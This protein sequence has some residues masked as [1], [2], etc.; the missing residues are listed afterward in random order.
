[1]HLL[2]ARQSGRHLSG[3]KMVQNQH[4]LANPF[5]RSCGTTSSLQDLLQC[6][7][8]RAQLLDAI[9]PQPLLRSQLFGSHALTCIWMPH[10]RQEL[11][12]TSIPFSLLPVAEVCS[13]LQCGQLPWLIDCCL[14]H[15]VSICCIAL[16]S[17]SC[18]VQGLQRQQ[19]PA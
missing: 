18:V 16:P 6:C 13:F 14:R 2:C 8:T 19:L 10:A 15:Y 9:G 3:H 1:M 7:R 5:L 17:E 4:S 12:H 11:C